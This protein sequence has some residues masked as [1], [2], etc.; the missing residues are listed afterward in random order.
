M[1]YGEFYA[2]SNRIASF[3]IING[4]DKG[5]RVAIVSENRIE[6]CA[7][8]MAIVMCGG[9]ALP[10]DMNLGSDE[11][12]NL[13]IDSE[14]KIIFYS[15]KTETNVLK[16]I[17]GIG[18]KGIAFD[19]TTEYWSDE[20]ISAAPVVSPDDIASIIYTSGTTGNPKG[21]MLTHKNFCSDAEAVIKAGIVTPEDNVL[22]ILP[23]HHTYPFMCAFLVPLFI[24]AAITFSPGLKS[25]EIMSAIKEKNISI[26][27]GVPRLFEMIRDGIISRIRGGNI[28]HLLLFAIKVCGF[29]RGRF[30]IN[31]GRIFFIAVHKN[32][33]RLR[34]FASGGAR[35]DP[36]VMKDLE[37]IGF[38][39]LEGYGLTETSPVITFNPAKVRKPGSVGIPLPDV[40]IRTS[41]DGEI[42][43]KG[44]MVM[45]G[46]YK[47]ETATNEAIKEGWLL[48]G[49][50]GY[51]DSSGYLFI[52]G[53]KKEVIVLAS[54]KN[55][56]PDEVERF[57]LTIPLIKELCITEKDG[58]LHAVIAPDFEYARKKLIGNISESL[59]WQI[60]DASMK[61]SE[62]MRIK[63][64]TI[65]STP[66]PRTPLGK[67]RRFMIKD[68]ANIGDKGLKDRT[69]DT[70]LLS[71]EIGSKVVYCIASLMKEKNPLR[72]DDSI[73]LDIGFDS[74][75]RLE[76]LSSL[77][78]TFSI[79]L[80]TAFISEVQTVNDV[81]LRIKEIIA[82][83]GA[84][85]GGKTIWR[86][87][88]GNVLR[89]EPFVADQIADALSMVLFFLLKC[90]FRLFFSLRAKGIEN[91]PDSGPYIITPNHTSY[92][93]GFVIASALPLKAYKKL[94]FLGFQRYF[95]GRI[96]TIIA[97]LGHVI[98]M[99]TET[100][101]ADAMQTAGH[102]IDKG[103]ALCIFP[104]G[105]RSFNGEIMEFKKG[106][107]ILASTRDTP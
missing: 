46:Y 100:F 104:E 98:P 103:K 16:A 82:V 99:D 44:P 25:Q 56:Y 85:K 67:L 15:A 20:K 52:T 65:S 34:F 94:Y 27:V 81:V 40:E 55:I 24:G 2:L 8:Y 23:L 59:K 38:T 12:R 13:V 54:G 7:A 50:T 26:V 35:L 105:G 78:D 22:S 29:L 51:L 42:L 10:I 9:I 102:L 90:F 3:L 60:N 107:S 39:I 70:S 28:A 91:L 69:P 19:G 21:V 63:G 6:W 79:K 48:T 45:K 106:V 57:Y 53:R 80:P 43:A 86:T 97:K 41:D 72:S 77:E 88:E 83:S 17:A 71:D 36:H 95:T 89:K 68:V 84:V 32:F 76:L 73:E 47:N 66:L 87:A 96:G 74:L 101:L 18:I 58:Q 61:L 1:T 11:I 31:I 30:D 33:P 64:Y 5:D 49:D 93:D 14:A 62:Y 75:K 92:L 37:A 4:L